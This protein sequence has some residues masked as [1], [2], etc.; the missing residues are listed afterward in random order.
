MQVEIDGT[1]FNI[2][3]PEDAFIVNAGDMLENIS[4]GFFTSA[5]HRMLAQD[6]GKERFSMILFVHPTD[7]TRLDPLSSCIEQTGGVQRYAPGTRKEFLWERLLELNIA[8]GLLEPYSKTGHTERQ[9][10]YARESKQVV[11]MLIQN[12]LASPELIEKN[13]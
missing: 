4:N 13:L 6:P 9:L 12:G 10:R 3:V 2:V 7:D 11:E 8:P 5:R 1:W